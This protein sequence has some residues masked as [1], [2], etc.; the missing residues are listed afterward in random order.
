MATVIFTL[1]G[2]GV[3]G[4]GGAL[5]VIVTI[6]WCPGGAL[7]V[8]AF[9]IQ[10]AGIAVTTGGSI[11]QWFGGHLPLFANPL[12]TLIGPPFIGDRGM[13]RISGDASIGRAGIAVIHID[14]GMD[15]LPRD[16]TVD[17]TKIVIIHIHRDMFASGHR[18][19]TVDR[20]GVPII[21]RF[22]RVGAAPI[23][24]TGSCLMAGVGGSAAIDRCPRLAAGGWVTRLN[25]VTGIF[26]VAG[27]GGTGAGAGRT[28]VILGTGITITTGGGV[29][30]LDLF[31]I[32]TRLIG[33]NIIKIAEWTIL[34]LGITDDR[35]LTATFVGAGIGTDPFSGTTGLPRLMG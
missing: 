25:P 13:D 33:T 19:T 6:L 22:Y 32:L 7:S 17:S 34:G 35:L 20:A 15:R 24:L 3:T 16:T 9:V 18:I 21:T 4:V 23:G 31:A 14:G 5:V 11:R 12:V 10:G 2:G 30:G 8:G 26:V 29:V 1:S 27:F 28:L